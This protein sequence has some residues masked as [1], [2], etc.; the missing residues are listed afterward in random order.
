MLQQL[1]WLGEDGTV[2]TVPQSNDMNGN[3]ILGS[4]APMVGAWLNEDGEVETI[5]DLQ[6]LR[7]GAWLDEDNEVH[8]VNDLQNLRNRMGA[9]LDEDG[10]YHSVNDLQNLNIGAW[11]DE[12]G[13][14]HTVND[15]QNLSLT[16][17]DVVQIAMGVLSGAL[18][19]ED[20]NDYVTCLQDS[21]TVV[22][23]VEDAIVNFEKESISGVAKGLEDIAN[24]L[25]VISTAIKTCSQQKDIA[26]LKKLEAML[27]QF[28]DPKSFA[29]HV[30]KD[31][32][33][34]GV[35][36]YHQITDAITQ[37][38]AGKYEAFG[39]DIGDSL[40]LVLVGKMQMQTNVKKV[41]KKKLQVLLI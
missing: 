8:T 1:A 13:E 27:A 6:N 14:L 22:A 5:N 24:G 26:Q 31:L 4:S 35:D 34:N 11:L 38:K 25:T 18:K 28:K 7:L 29:Y 39:E 10:N 9:W 36:I 33:V 41:Q 16:K 17:V 32:L 15:L 3:P 23:D 12:D 20:L 30:G 19:T 21:E 2:H 37:Y 40:A